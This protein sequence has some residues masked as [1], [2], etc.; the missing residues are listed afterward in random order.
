MDF[1]ELVGQLRP[2]RDLPRRQPR[3]HGGNA[4][5]AQRHPQVGRQDVPRRAAAHEPEDPRHAAQVLRLRC[6]HD[7]PESLRQA[8]ALALVP[9]RHDGR[10][11]GRRAE[12]GR[13]SSTRPIRR[14][15]RRSRRRGRTRWPT[16]SSTTTSSIRRSCAIASSKASRWRAE[17]V[18]SANGASSEPGLRSRH[19][20]RHQGVPRRAVRLRCSAWTRSRK[21][22]AARTAWAERGEWKIS[23]AC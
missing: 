20:P 19:G 5:R 2:S 7:G 23:K 13:R 14:G 4:G 17:R 8:D 10:D 1:L 15:P 3:R 11:A 6:R 16:A 9:G 18:R 12:A 21:A 22:V